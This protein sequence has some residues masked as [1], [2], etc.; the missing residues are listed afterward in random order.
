MP[1][2]AGLGMLRPCCLVLSAFLPLSFG[3]GSTLYLAA[4][5][6]SPRPPVEVFDCVK[7][8]ILVLGYTQ[9]SIDVEDHRITARKYD[10]EARFADS[11]FHRMIERLAIEVGSSSEGGALLRIGAHTFA[12]LATQRGPTEIEQ[13]ASPAVRAAAHAL[14]EACGS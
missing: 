2:V 8:Q 13:S 4:N 1:E 12:E 11:R 6:R 10:R 7:R 3:C 9:T 14:L 5:G